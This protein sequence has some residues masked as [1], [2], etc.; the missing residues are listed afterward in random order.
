MVLLNIFQSCF[1]HFNVIVCI[2]NMHLTSSNLSTWI[3]SFLMLATQTQGT[4]I[5]IQYV[6]VVAIRSLWKLVADWRVRRPRIISPRE[7]S[8]S[9]WDWNRTNEVGHTVVERSLTNA[10]NFKLVYLSSSKSYD[11]PTT[12][13]QPLFRG[14]F[15]IVSFA[16][17][18][19]TALR[20]MSHLKCFDWQKWDRMVL[21]GNNLEC[22]NPNWKEKV[23]KPKAQWDPPTGAGVMYCIL[24]ASLT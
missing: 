9:N 17:Y 4:G 6:K 22:D 3:Q 13:I 20:C 16:G 8:A 7:P 11:H 12:I 24:F 19:Y 2:S 14:I 21:F 1:T 18:I 23:V 10:T 15:P 5:L